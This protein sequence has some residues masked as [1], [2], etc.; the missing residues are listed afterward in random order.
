MSDNLDRLAKA[1]ADAPY[2]EYRPSEEEW[3]IAPHDVKS[4]AYEQARAALDALGLKDPPTHAVDW[5]DVKPLVGAV[6]A[7]CDPK[8]WLCSSA[9]NRNWHCPW[10][11]QQSANGEGH[12]IKHKTDCPVGKG[13][14]ALARFKE[15]EA[16]RE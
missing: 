5:E 10:C 7:L 16:Q 14:A 3:A 2:G 9:S 15:L 12:D 8:D 13:I 1:I 11:E 4:L 6:K